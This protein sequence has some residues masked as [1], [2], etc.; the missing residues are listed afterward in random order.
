M[1]VV[2]MVLMS[3][4]PI[5]GSMMLKSQT[6]M[7]VLLSRYAR[8]PKIKKLQLTKLLESCKLHSSREYLL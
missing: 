7:S 2:L 5:S 3:G 8:D 6:K 4:E 1:K